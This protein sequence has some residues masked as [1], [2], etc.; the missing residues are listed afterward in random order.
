MSFSSRRQTAPWLLLL[1][2]L[3]MRTATAEEPVCIE[4]ASIDELKDT[5]AA[6]RTTSADLVRG[7]T[8][9]IEAYDR[10][11]P[12]LNSVRELNPDALAI[13]GKLDDTRPSV[14]RPLAGIPLL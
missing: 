3:L 6:G 12:R 11:G 1:L 4:N 9:R 8:A 7:Y 10:A 5:L 13:A 14:T 2:A